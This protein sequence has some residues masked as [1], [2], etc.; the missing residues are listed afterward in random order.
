M[1]IFLLQGIISFRGDI[2]ILAYNLIRWAGGNLP[3]IK[4]HASVEKLK[5]QLLENI[6]SELAKCFGNQPIPGTYLCINTTH[7]ENN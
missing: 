5:K 1:V 4:P 6:D 2:E 7:N 3:W